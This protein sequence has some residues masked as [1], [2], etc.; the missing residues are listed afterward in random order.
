MAYELPKD[1]DGIRYH[2]VVDEGDKN[3]GQ[4]AYGVNENGRYVPLRVDDEGYALTKLT[5]SNVELLG[6][7]ENNTTQIG[8]TSRYYSRSGV[9]SASNAQP[10]DVSKYK[11]KMVVVKNNFDKEISTLSVRFLKTTKTGDYNDIY[12]VSSKGIPAGSTAIVSSDV[13]LNM[14]QPAIGM[15]VYFY[16]PTAPTTCDVS[17]YFL[18][19]VL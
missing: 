18:G 10:F 8:I 19:G 15:F 14:A 7:I 4:V 17:V 1:K 6:A 16:M 13:S 11:T 5:G 3:P 9:T 12:R 2:G